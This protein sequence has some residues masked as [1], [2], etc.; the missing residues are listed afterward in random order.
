MK[1]KKKLAIHQQLWVFILTTG[2]ALRKHPLPH[3]KKN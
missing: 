3:K 2:M 1:Y